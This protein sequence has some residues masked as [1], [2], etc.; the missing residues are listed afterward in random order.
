MSG[1]LEQDAG[2]ISREGE[3]AGRGRRADAGSTERRNPASC[4][5]LPLLEER[6]F[7]A[8]VTTRISPHIL[9]HAKVWRKRRNKE[10][11]SVIHIRP[12]FSVQADYRWWG[13]TRGSWQ[14][15][16]ANRQLPII[17]DLLG[18]QSDLINT[19]PAAEKPWRAKTE[20]DT[21]TLAGWPRSNKTR[22]FTVMLR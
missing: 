5:A 21:D 12:G 1:E 20:M 15:E 18:A 2:Q 4:H 13:V 16:Q 3:L 19:E 7:T 14:T 10:Q 8:W 17:R 22:V 11:R 6:F 9:C